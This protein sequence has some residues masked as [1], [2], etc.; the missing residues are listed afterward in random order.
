MRKNSK[1][2]KK[3]QNYEKKIAKLRKN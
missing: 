1:I 2:L 3:L